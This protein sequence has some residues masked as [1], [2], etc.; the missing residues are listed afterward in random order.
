MSF[1][2][3]A[4]IIGGALGAA[5]SI[6]GGMLARGSGAGGMANEAGVKAF[7][8]ANELAATDRANLSPWRAT[9]N[10]AN[11]QVAAL[12]GLGSVVPIGDPNT[13]GWNGS[14]RIDPTNWQQDQRNAMA[15]FQT[16]PGYQFRMQQGINALDRGAG[17]RGMRFS[18]AQ[19]KALSD[20]G[21]NTGSAEYGNYFNRLAGASGQGLTAATAQNTTANQALLPGIQDQYGGAGA[22]AGY[23]QGNANAGAAGLVGATNSLASGL[24]A[25]NWA[26]LFGNGGQGALGGTS[27]PAFA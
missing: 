25:T 4:P 26:K 2:S 14:S 15:R 24:T 27:G 7:Q 1:A 20:Y 8:Q 17:A 5:G 3:L 22:G 19:A 11:N 18:G 6:G 23:A 21:Q 12:L 16:D 13:P 9:G 10:A